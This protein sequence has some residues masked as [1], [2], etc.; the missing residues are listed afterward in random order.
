LRL[1]I[2]VSALLSPPE[3]HVGVGLAVLVFLL[4]LVEDERQGHQRGGDEP[5]VG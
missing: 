1:P 5:R 3:T 4:L 2:Y